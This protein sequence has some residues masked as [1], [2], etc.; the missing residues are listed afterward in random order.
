MKKLNNLKWFSLGVTLCLLISVLVVPSVA[1]SRSEQISA[2]YNGL[3]IYINGV[4]L[5]PKDANGN[6][7]EPFIV[8][9]TTYLPLRAI[10]SAVGYEVKYDATGPAVYLA[11]STD[12][13]AT[14]SPSPSTTPV[15]AFDTAYQQRL[16]SRIN[17]CLKSANTAYDNLQ[18]KIND[19]TSRG[20]GR[21]STADSARSAQ[22]SIYQDIGE[23]EVLR[24]DIIGAKSN[25]V[26]PGMD[27]H[28]SYFELIYVYG[29]NP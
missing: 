12:I 5:A 8:G 4:K 10:A 19:L 18:A 7:V 25:D 23:M 20:M 15:T 3:K 6:A 2:D 13:T 29:V 9:G 28:V 16:L 21:S 27:N 11:S 17:V 1:E 26:L 24:S 22:Q 14:P